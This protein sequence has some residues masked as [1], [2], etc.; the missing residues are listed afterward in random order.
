VHAF[1]ARTGEKVWSYFFGTAAVNPSPVVQGNYVYI[2][3]GEEN[4]EPGNTVLGRVV[5]LDASQVADGKPKLVWK[6][7]GLKDKFSSPLIDG[8]R[9]YVCDENARLYCLD[10]KTGK[11]IWKHKYGRNARGSP[12]LADGKIYVGEVNSEFHI[13]KPGPKKCTELHSQAFASNTKEAVEVEINGSPAVADG[14]VYFMTTE[15]LYCIG[16]KDRKPEEVK[17][18]PGPKEAAPGEKATH[19]QV[20]PAEVTL[21]PGESVTLTARLFDQH[22][23]FL[24]ET[25]AEWSLG[26]MLPPEPV[27]GFPP[28]KEKPPAPPKLAGEITPDGK[29]T[30]A[31]ALAGQFGNVIARAEGLTGR[32]RVRVAPV[33]PYREDF[34]KVAVGGIPGGWVNTQGKFVV[35]EKGG[36]KVLAKTALLPSPL[37]ARG[38]GYITVPDVA[39]YTI[40][41]DIAGTKVGGDLPEMGLINKR[42]LLVMDGNKQRLRLAS[43]MAV[44]RIDQTVSWDMK[45]DVWYRF[46]LTVEQKGDKAIARGKVWERGKPEPKEWTL[47]VEDPAPNRHGSPGLYAFAYGILP[48]QKGTEV[49]YDNVVVTPLKQPVEK[50]PADGGR[51]KTEKKEP[52]KAD[53]GGK[54]SA[55]APP[56]VVH[57]A[58]YCPCCCSYP[59]VMDCGCRCYCGGRGRF[60]CR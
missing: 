56:V 43:W 36:S 24:R 37:V 32:A 4:P 40:E 51:P 50:K 38:Y 19:L 11:E 26:A 23:R 44:P 22:G 8:D 15:E 27:P 16:L 17:I 30:A 28:S 31:R 6:K 46:K 58:Y 42:Y 14:K 9:L 49:Y 5:C 59:V 2:A 21:H 57:P 47:E 10:A 33:L 55:E 13:L 12:V 20:F 3:H 45:P 29:F 54:P 41:A 34:E 48:G 1:K 39:D 18:P 52:P 53:R 7:D 25:K 60:R 35:V